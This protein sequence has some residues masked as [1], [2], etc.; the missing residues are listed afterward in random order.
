MTAIDPLKILTEL[1]AA[2]MEIGDLKA[3]LAAVQWRRVTA[4]DESLPPSYMK[5]VEMLLV[6][7]ADGSFIAMTSGE[8]LRRLA[9]SGNPKIKDYYWRPYLPPEKE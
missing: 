3:Q 5:Q 6:T 7:E 8:Q 4:R 9:A 1:Q 2:R